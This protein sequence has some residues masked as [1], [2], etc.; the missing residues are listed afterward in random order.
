MNPT[1]KRVRVLG[2]NNISDI[3]LPF[4]NPGAAYIRDTLK[5]NPLSMEMDLF[6]CRLGVQGV[7]Y[8]S[9]ILKVN[10]RLV[11]VD[12]RW[13]EIGDEGVKW[14]AEALKVNDILT[15]INL[16]GNGIEEEGAK[17]LAEALK[18]NTTLTHINLGMNCIGKMGAKWLA[19]ALKIN[20]TLTRINLDGNCIRDEEITWAVEAVSVNSALT[21]SRNVIGDEGEKFTFEAHGANIS[22]TYV[23]LVNSGI[24]D[25]E[26][27]W[28][29][30][31]ANPH[32]RRSLNSDMC[33][34]PCGVIK[35]LLERNG[36]GVERAR[37]ASLYVMFARKWQ[38]SYELNGYKG[39]AHLP[40][41]V[42]LIIAKMVWG[43][44]GSKCWLKE[45][46]PC[47]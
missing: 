47:E 40:A 24:R 7:I 14:I 25:M 17:W 42:S 29:T 32:M 46:F 22:L 16:R 30:D 1:G 19:E 41:E 38:R 18:V 27:K 37:K 26:A 20:S 15:R 21:L 31:P 39:L 10:T 9:R 2:K 34:D 11:Y 43:T 36:L 4:E 45:Y 5:L 8:L 23:T 13:N 35:K 6:R 28:T 12:L 3:D 33:T 44:N